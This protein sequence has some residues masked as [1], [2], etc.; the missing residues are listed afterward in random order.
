MTINEVDLDNQ[1]IY[2]K[3][4]AVMKRRVAKSTKGSYKRSNITFI[5]WMFDHHNKYLSLLQPMLHDMMKTKNL[6]DISWMTTRG[7]WSKSMHGIRAICHE[8]LQTINT[9][10]QDSIPVKLEHLTFTIFSRF[11]STFKKKVKK[12]V[13]K[14]KEQVTTR[15]LKLG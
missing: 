7:K 13:D 12:E 3:T 1:R 9:D 6:E 4:E 15:L 8:A 14:S 5:L 11:F 2:I 10:V